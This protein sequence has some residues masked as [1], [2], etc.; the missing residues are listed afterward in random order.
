MKAQINC[1]VDPPH[2]VW[3]VY[4]KVS[5]GKFGWEKR[6]VFPSKA[7]AVTYCENGGLEWELA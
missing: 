5:P 1:N 7:K 6:G 2:P 4:V 3:D